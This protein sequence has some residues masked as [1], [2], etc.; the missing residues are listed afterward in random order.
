MPKAAPMPMVAEL[1]TALEEALSQIE[2]LQAQV[3]AL[4]ERVATLEQEQT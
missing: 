4:T 3:A 2:S 1:R